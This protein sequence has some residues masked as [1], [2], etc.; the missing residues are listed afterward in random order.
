MA[1]SGAFNFTRHIP[2]LIEPD[3][4]NCRQTQTWC[5]PKGRDLQAMAEHKVLIMGVDEDDPRS[6]T[7]APKWP[8]WMSNS[9]KPTQSQKARL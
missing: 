3:S 9:S 7:N 8:T 1:N 2:A 4:R 5:S 6:T